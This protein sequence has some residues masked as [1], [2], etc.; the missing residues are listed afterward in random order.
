[1][2][3]G[4]SPPLSRLLVVKLSSLG[5][6]F[7]AL[8]A[9]HL[10]K[11]QT[12]ATI[13]WVCHDIYAGLVKCFRDVE[14]VIPFPRAS[15]WSRRAGF[16]QALRARSYDLVLDM[17]GLLKSAF[18]VARAARAPRRIGPSFS[19]EG[20]RLFYDAV[21]GPTNKDR[22]AVEENLDLVRYLGLQAGPVEFPVQFPATPHHFPGPGIGLLPCSRQARK[23][24]APERFIEVARALRAQ[25]GTTVVLLGGPAD[26]PVCDAIA[27]GA[28]EGI[29]NLCG[30]TSLVELG[31]L[32]KALDLLVTVD[33]GPMHMAAAVGTP[34]VALFGPTDPLRTG[35]YGPGHRVIR[36][37]GGLSLITASE[38]VT[39]AIALLDRRAGRA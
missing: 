30:R 27:R 6:L 36:R 9:V 33:S 4:S 29:V 18:L 15:Y 17:Q 20:A 28:G 7:H 10:I 3:A 39:E 35:P 37:G 31:G 38:V 16:R 12:G 19:R 2:S 26:M 34:V 24:W 11:A 14:Q 21:A 23:N 13:D 22:H 32:L 1:M 8:P 25:A 5:D